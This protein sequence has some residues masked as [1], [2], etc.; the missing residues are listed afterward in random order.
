MASDT[1]VPIV[2]PSSDAASSWGLGDGQAI[3]WEY[4]PAPEARDI[5]HLRERYG[6]FIGGRDLSSPNRAYTYFLVRGNGQFLVK[7]RAGA[8]TSDILAWRADPA[9]TQA[10]ST[11]K[12]TYR[13]LLICAVVS[14]VIAV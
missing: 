8:K 2:T 4:A 6:L 11:G 13:A 12:A 5:V 9:V 7:S 3:P 1:R 10:D 14:S